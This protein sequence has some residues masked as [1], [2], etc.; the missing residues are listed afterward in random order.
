MRRTAI[1][2]V[3]AFLLMCAPDTSE[4]TLI[5]TGEAF[6]LAF[7]AETCSMCWSGVLPQVSMDGLLT[8]A[9]AIGSFWDPWYQ[10]Y[11]SGGVLVVTGITGSLTI[12]GNGT[13]SLSFLDPDFSGDGWS[14]PRGDGSYLL[15]FGPRYLVFAANG[16]DLNTRIINDNAY[17]LFQ[18]SNPDTGYGSQVP[19]Q[20]SAVQVPEPQP[21]T[22][23]AFA[24][25]ALVLVHRASQTRPRAS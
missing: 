11:L 21:S 14:A 4:A 18:W 8:V 23:L 3:L 20:W 1:V 15:P 17:N 19:V 13:Y 12:Q 25:I 2:A 6:D 7:H 5:T 16:S 22:L 24:F 10:T 9:P